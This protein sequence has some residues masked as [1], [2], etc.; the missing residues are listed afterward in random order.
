[1][2]SVGPL[3]PPLDDAPGP[4]TPV[5]PRASREVR[6]QILADAARRSRRRAGIWRLLRP[7]PVGAGL[8]VML[9][10]ASGAAAVR[11]WP[12]LRGVVPASAETESP[13]RPESAPRSSRVHSVPSEVVAPAP[14]LPADPLP[15]RAEHE[16][17]ARA[18][19]DLLARANQL[20]AHKRWGAAEAI[21]LRVLE[22]RAGAR[23]SSTA[24]LAAAELRLSKLGRPRAALQLFERALREEPEGALAEQARHGIARAFRALGDTPGEA[25]ALRAFIA[26]HPGSLMLPHAERRLRVID[27]AR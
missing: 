21:Y 1:M 26:A 25:R 19:I 4:A 22:R 17:A 20:R 11:L 14:D 6:E 5:S 15:S 10:V 3:M 9:V 27:T 13:E 8:A 18:P 7:A 24:A 2:K 16:A 23:V 12:V